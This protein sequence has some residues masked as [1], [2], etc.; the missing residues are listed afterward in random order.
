MI[1][2]KV[3][4]SDLSAVITSPPRIQIKSWLS[5][6]NKIKHLIPRKSSF[7]GIKIAQLFKDKT[8]SRKSLN[9]GIE[10]WRALALTRD[11]GPNLSLHFLELIFLK[12]CEHLWSLH[13]IDYDES[14]LKKCLEMLGSL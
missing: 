7:L 6:K 1:D 8:W 2:G 10:L 12:V 13:L 9:C 4:F 14:K 5:G 3:H 11:P